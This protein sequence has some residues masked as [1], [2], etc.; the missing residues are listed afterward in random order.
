MTPADRARRYAVSC[1]RLARRLH[2]R[3]V[4]RKPGP[5]HH[6]VALWPVNCAKALRDLLSAPGARRVGMFAEQIKCVTLNLTC[7]L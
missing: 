7:K 4:R 2:R 6:L 5:P 3:P 1:P